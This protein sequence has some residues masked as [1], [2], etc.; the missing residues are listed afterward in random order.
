MH[1]KFWLGDLKAGGD[2][3]EYLV[4]DGKMMLE[5]IVGRLWAECVWLRMA[6]TSGLL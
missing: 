5:W 1:K 2:N 3:L 6:T 4:V